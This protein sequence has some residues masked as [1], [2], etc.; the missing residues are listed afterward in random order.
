MSNF[1][2]HLQGL[3]V[4]IKTL[5]FPGHSEGTRQ[6]C[7]SQRALTEAALSKSIV[8]Q[9]IVSTYHCDVKPL[10][11]GGSCMSVPVCTSGTA[12]DVQMTCWMHVVHAQSGAE[13]YFRF[14]VRVFYVTT[15]TRAWHGVREGVYSGISVFLLTPV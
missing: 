12:N 9:N 2:T 8:H 4:A 14:R 1:A 7:P 11:V 15:S 5:T 6:Q 10:L 13:Y 3:D